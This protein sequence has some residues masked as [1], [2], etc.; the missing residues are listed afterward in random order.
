MCLPIGAVISTTHVSDC[1]PPREPYD[2]E[3][4]QPKAVKIGA[5]IRR[6]AALGQRLVKSS[7]RFISRVSPP[8][9]Q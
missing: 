3:Y 9:L 6:V 5:V 8:L 1:C 7:R 4:N 2:G